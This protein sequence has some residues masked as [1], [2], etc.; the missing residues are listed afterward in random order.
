M[1]SASRHKKKKKNKFGAT[2]PP[3]IDYLKEILR[4]YPDGGQILKE[5]IQNA[6]DAGASAVV[7]IHDERHYGTQSLWSEELRKYQG[8]ALYAFN[9]AAFTEEDWEGIQN[10]GRSIKQDDPTKVGRFGIGFNSVYHITDL[11][12]V[13]SSKNLAIF[14]PQKMMF[15]DEEE[16][17]RWSLD[18]EEDRESILNMRDQFQPF[19]NIV[20]QVNNC[21][22]EKVIREEQYF[23]G[24]LFRFPLRNEA[25]E[26]SDNLYDSKKVTELFDSFIF[27]ADIGLL[28]LRNVS[29]ITLLHIDTNGS[30]SQRLKVSVSHH[31]LE[32][33]GKHES[34]DRKTCF[35]TVSH[36]SQQMEEKSQW[37]VTP[38]L[39]KQ[40]YIL[41]IDSLANKM[42]FNPQVDV[43]FKLE[44][45]RSLCNGRLSCF[46]PLPNN[47]SN[48]TGLPVHINASFGL[49][50][51]RR[52]IK[53]QEEDQKNDEAAMWNELLM[54]DLLPLIYLMMILDAIQLSRCSALPAASV[55]NIWPDLTK[56]VHVD[57]WHK[58][59]KDIL[60]CLF[61]YEIF[62]LADNEK[63]WVSLSDAVF[64]DN[65]ICSDTMS[66]VSKLLIKKGENLV[67]VPEHVLK[68]VKGTFAR[69]DTLKIVTPSFVRDVLHR[70]DME[71]L[72]KDDKYSLLEFVLSDERYTELQGLKL[73]P[74]SDGTFT[75]FSDKEQNTV[76]IDN[77]KFPRSLM[78]FCKERFL[79][80][81]L[82]NSCTMHLRKLATNTKYNIINLDAKH[83][84][85]LTKKHLPIDWRETQAHVTWKPAEDH[86]PPKSWIAE[87][88][89]FLSTECED[90]SVFIGLPLIPLEPLQNS[91]NLILLARLQRNST[92]IFQSSRGSILSDHVQKVVNMAGCTVIKRDEC[93]RHHDIESY[94]LPASPRNVLQVLMNSARDQVIKHI[95]SASL[96]EK[97]EFKVYLSSLDSLSNAEQNL[98]S[99]LPIFS[100]MSGKYVAVKS[101]QAVVL[102][103]NPSIPNNLPMPETIVQC[104]NEADR[105]LLSL[106]NIELLDAAKVAIC[107]V[108]CINTASFQKDEEQTIMSWILDHGSV[109]LSQNE[110]LLTKAKDLNFIE[111]NQGERKQASNFFD[112]GNKTF[113][114]L[115]EA[116]LFPP[117]FYT[118][119]QE[120]LQSLQ[121]LGLK[122][123]E[124]EISTANILQVMKHVQ[125]ISI[126][127][128]NKAF[129]KVDTLVRV[130]NG[131][132]LLSKLSKTER[133]EIMQLQ[134]VPCENPKCLN[135]DQRR[136][137]YKPDEVRDSKYSAI[138]GYVMPLTSKLTARVCKNLG[139]NDP[140]PAEKVLENLSV[141]GSVAA[142]MINPDS[143][144]QFKTMLH[145]IYKYMQENVGNFREALNAK[146]IPWLW[147][148]R[149]F[150]SPKDIV[151]AYP[152]ELDLN[153]YIKKV[154][155]EFLKYENLLRECGVKETLS[156][157]ELEDVLHDIKQRIDDRDPPYGDST[158]LKLSIAVIN[159]MRKNEKFLKDNTPVPVM[160]QNKNF[161]LQY[162]S[163][164]VFCDIS[165]E[166]LDDLKQDN[167]ELY[168]IHEEVLPLT[169][170][171]LKVPF[172]STR[173]LKPQ[174]ITA[175]QEYF[176]IEQCGQSE[177]ITLRIK[178]ILKE[179]NEESDIFKE[180]IQNAE[181][182]GASTCKF[183][184]DFRKHRDPP[185]TLIDDG[186]A[187]CNGPCL[188]IFNNELFSEED[189]KN[190]VKVGSASKANKVEKIGKFGLGFNAVYHVSDIPSILSGKSLL[191][192]DPNVTH[193]EKHIL[194]KGNPGIKLDPFQERLYKS[195]P[196]QFKSYEGIFDCDL[197][198]QNSKK[199]YNGTLIKLPFRTV[200][201]ANKSEISSKV[202]DEERINSFKYNLIE[203]SQNHLLF[204]KNIKS[205]SLQIV[206]EIAFTPLRDDQIETPLKT[207]KEVMN[208]IAVSND[209]LL[210]E[211]K[212]NF[213]KGGI[214]C[215]N[216][217]DYNR[218]QIV[219]IVKNH[220]EGSLTQYWLLYSCI[221]TKDS[222]QMFQ[223][224][225]EHEHVFS[226][227][228]G[229]I[230]VPLHRGA[231]TNVW[232]PDESLL[233]GQAFCFLPLTIET[234]LPVHVNG[235]FAVTSNRKGLWEKGLKSEWNKALLKD[236]INSAYIT[237]L[238]ELKK[239]AQ[240]GNLQNYPF[241]AFWPN[242]EK[243]SKAFLPMVESF[244]SAVAQN[245]NGNSLELFSNGRNWCSMDKATF[246][247]PKIEE[248]RAIGNIAM[249]VF[250]NMGESYSCV[251]S[252][253]SWVRDSFSQC[254]FKEMIKQ[255][256]INWPEFY[257]LVLKNLS[258]LDTHS[259]NALVLN[260][261]DLNDPSVDD[262]L[263]RYPCIPTQNCK[264]LQ[265]IN[266]VVNPSSKV[267]CLYELEE[268]RFVEGTATD[269]FSPKRIQRLSD[270]GMLTDRLPF[271]DIIERAGKVSRVCQQD[272]P[273]CRKHLQ[274]LI[275]SM[276]DSSEDV[277]SQCWAS[278]S[279]I[280][281]LPAVAPFVQQNKNVILLK[282]PA[283]VYS[284][285]CRNIV[286]MTEFTV[287]H[288]NLQ[289]HNMDSVL[290]KLQIRT[291][292]PV[293]TVLQQL[294]KAHQ[295]SDAIE[296]AALLNIAQFCYEYL[297]TYLLEHKYTN[298]IVAFAKSHPFIF[299]EDHFVNVRSVARNEGFEE[300]PYL[301][302][303]PA[304]FSKFERL[305]DCIGITKQFTKEQFVAT[306]EDIKALYGSQPLSMSDLHMCF[307]ILIKGLY[308]VKNK[309]LEN[310]LIPNE[311]GVLTSSCE[312]KFND[313]PW[314]PVSAGVKLTHE[315][316][317]RAVACHFGVKTTRHHTLKNHLVSGF[318][319]L[320]REFGQTEKLT[321][322]IK[323][324]INA[325]PSKK[326]I[327]KEL[328][329]NAD[330]A[331]ATEIH[332]VWD[333]RKHQTK[334]I[335]G[336]KWELVQGP[337]L[338]VYNN[339]TF[340][341]ADLQGIQ[342]LGEGGKHGTLGKTGKYGLGFN[343]VYHLTDCPSILTGDNWLCI[344][345]PN[346]KYVEDA[347]KQSPGCM[348]L[349]TD[350]F[351]K[352]F[353][354]V[355]NT[356]LPGMFALNSGTMFRLPL[357]TEIMAE[358]SEISRH[359][360]TDCNMLQLYNA[361]TEDP[362]GLIIFLKHITKIQFSEIS[363]DGKKLKCYF[364]VE[365]KYTEKSMATKENFNT[366]VQKSLMSGI[367]EPFKTIYSMQ[368][369]YGNK[370][371]QWIIAECFG[372]FK[373][374]HVRENKQMHFK[375]PQAALAACVSS[376]Y[377]HEFIGRA[378][379][380]LPL[381][382]NTG[383][384][385]HVNANFEVDSS[386]RD[387]WKEDGDSLK[388]DWNKTLKVNIISPLY[389]DLLYALRT[390][391]KKDTPTA[392]T[393]LKM[394][395]E[396]F[397]LKYFPCISKEVEKVWYEMILEVYRSFSEDYVP[398][399]PTVH[400]VSET[401]SHHT[402]NTSTLN[403]TV[404]WHSVS[405]P[406]SVNCPYFTTEH[407]DGIFEILDDIGLKLVPHS[408]KI[409]K[410]KENF[411][412]AGVNVSEVS[413]T[414]VVN[415][416]KQISLNDPTQTVNGLPLPISQTL[417]KDKTR[418]SKLLSFCLTNTDAK[419]AIPVPD[420]DGLPLLLTQDQMLR[421]FN[422]RSPK[423]ISRFSS[424]FHEYQ[425]MFADIEV[426]RQH[427]KILR[428]KSFIKDLTIAMGAKY[429]KA[430]LTQML[431]QSLPDQK[432]Q[433]Y[434][435]QKETI[436]WLKTLWSFFDDQDKI[437][438]NG[439]V[440]SEIKKHFNDSPILPVIC[441]SQNNTHFLQTMKN[442][443]EVILNSEN[444][445]AA[446]LIK[447]G[448]MKLDCSFFIGLIN[449]SLKY[450]YPELLQTGDGGAV[451]GPVYRVPH[452]YFVELSNGE[453][454]K[455][456][457]FLQRRI[458]DSK[459]K[460]VYAKMLKSLPLFESISGKRERIDLHRSVFILNSRHYFVF[461][462]LFTIEGCDSIF[463]KYSW[464]NL[465]LAE[466]LNI[467]VLDDLEFCVQFILPFV[468]KMKETKLI[469]F[470]QLLVE[471]GL[472]DPRIVSTLRG[473][474]FIRDI[475]GSRQVASYFYDEKPIYRIMLTEERFVPEQFWN[476]FKGKRSEALCLLKT[477]GLKHEVS[478]EEIIQFAFQI[479]SETKGTTPLEVL[480]KRSKML[481]KTVLMRSE[482]NC[483]L[484]NRIANIKFIFPVKIQQ[485]LCDYHKPFAQEREVVAISGS[486]IERD[487]DHQCL[488]WTSMP[489]LPSEHW[490]PLYFHLKMKN[491]GAVVTPPPEQIA[492]NVRNICSSQCHTDS[493]LKTRQEVFRKSYA[494]LQSVKFDASLF[495]D[496]HIVLVEKGTTLVKT[497]QTAL[498]LRHALEFRPYLY[499]I[500]SNLMKFEDFFR[501][502]GVNERPTN[503][504][505]CTVLREIY[506]DSS[507]KDK[508]QANQQKT[509]QRVVQQ[510]FCLM[511]EEQKGTFFQN[512][513]LYLPSTDGRLYKSSTLFFND[514]VFQASRL[515]GPLETKLKL[516][517]KLNYCH[518]GDDHYEHQRYV[519][520]LLPQ[521]RPKFLSE[522]I[523][524]NLDGTS[525]Q[526]CDYKE[527]CEF[528]NWIKDH[529]CSI[530]FLHGLACLI[531]EDSNGRI[532]QTD[533][534]QMCGT[535]F[536]KIQ[537]ICCET[538]QTELLL[539]L[540]P[541][542]GSKTETDVYVKKQEDGCT[543]YLKHHGD[544]AHKVVNEVTMCLTKEIN[545]LMKNCLAT[546]RLAVLGQLLLCDNMEDVEK[547]LEK[548]G[549]HNSG[550]KEEGHSVL[551]KPGC[552]IPE[553]WHD[554]LDMSF[555]NNFESGE[556]VGFSKDESGEYLYAIVIERLDDSLG[557]TRQ[558]PARYKIQ[559]GSD[560][561]IEVSS[562]DLYQFKREKKERMPTWFTCT[563][564]QPLLTSVPPPH[565][566][567]SV[568]APNRVTPEP[569]PRRAFPQTLKEAKKEIDQSLNE[570]WNMS[571]EDKR[572]ALKRLYLQWHPDKNPGNEELAA[573]AFKYL[574]TRIEELQQ[575]R[576]AHNTSSNV[577]DFRDNFYQWNTEAQSHR[578]GRERFHQKNYRREY[579]FWSHHRETPRPDRE[580]AKRWYEQAQCDINAAHNDT[581]GNTSEWCLFKV[582]QAVEKA[583]IAVVY[584]KIGKHLNNSS[585]TSLAQ[586]VSYYSSQLSSVPITVRQLIELGVDAKK[587]QYPNYHQSPHI[588]NTQYK[589]NNARRALDIATELLL[590]IDQ[591]I[592]G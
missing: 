455:L 49:T 424:L 241:Y 365:K 535:L 94:V 434:K 18:D 401:S 361:L 300:K 208:S 65:T 111:T 560:V 556:Y 347:T 581:G 251:L 417:I 132:N 396:D 137:L 327:L 223:R 368:I 71:N 96:H 127:S 445:I 32:L 403:Y 400:A 432:C 517:E 516:L 331:E 115:F 311:S 271:K 406:D 66:A 59:A 28:F 204:L 288:S 99:L 272:K 383:L 85:V 194:S 362:E 308:K 44:E 22:W 380:S 180:L 151:L 227:P 189:W 468:H 256:T 105:R 376:T 175:D 569:P 13:F 184:L 158:E 582:H 585:I 583:L 106:L 510:L 150:V 439:N 555:L 213:M 592:N 360:V 54:K 264:K 389:A 159:W 382:G 576:T 579:N 302:V 477:L 108:D 426:N 478:D 320:A 500:P 441:P 285:T 265:F 504:Q 148:Q 491:A 537:I 519:Q 276:K 513:P 421:V 564:V 414:V 590:K 462:N 520:L 457:C 107:L 411:K 117:P 461:H 325:Y 243:V 449:F 473:L 346:L 237:T 409:H 363:E 161:S 78:P 196:G 178:N 552:R 92:L 231:Q 253:P 25:S 60:K 46:L 370:Q 284:D 152:F 287:D 57:R 226:L 372:S 373:Q 315:L 428:E 125:N 545:A 179:Y 50:D 352:S 138:V 305:W 74:L 466:V 153:S 430:E 539:N 6:D 481:F 174:F 436:T 386:R 357:R 379:C 501:K 21:S 29:S 225:N 278:L 573:E 525:V 548:H 289:I 131:N 291:N 355:Y 3:F 221:G 77:E 37:L 587:T 527:G 252:L 317:P 547:A 554:C 98:L 169:A 341:E 364:L 310:C 567:T 440:F 246:L 528:G 24:T 503:Q 472:V 343:S 83:V 484:L 523:S 147:N 514:T 123:E 88:W 267:A 165:A 476:I 51:N 384:P 173:I 423:L 356:F 12:C 168:V 136:G 290:Q 335:F 230:A 177:P 334:K 485:A 557:Q 486:L 509:V 97:E 452:S 351:K 318:S 118:K 546:S 273:K 412:A 420:L 294:L 348:Y 181:D 80:I 93:L 338:C 124:K 233:Q 160:A 522:V 499:S 493:L 260:A 469:D 36:I 53:W 100:L 52:Y 191:I 374:N 193:L 344:S 68:D 577:G 269:F 149:E 30:C 280:P 561:F 494:H 521:A 244:Y 496:L 471:L 507:D 31:D 84:V 235:A 337:A 450:V 526:Y 207:S 113:Q 333:R 250:L 122:T 130:L 258:T 529:L 429:L 134:W 157:E 234:G 270:L 508:L 197:S 219:K 498:V 559:V 142:D 413:P 192:L 369:S 530:A 393:F 47:E 307:S 459:I 201:E 119:T 144:F 87:F 176:G 464:V 345:D 437:S 371:S 591:Y 391:I 89:K 254:G 323:N 187:L 186:M 479:E 407:H 205:I 114:D 75:S 8:P 277:N 381:P 483:N 172:L 433:L 42:R 435:A 589:V 422:S 281:F 34:L 67:T 398:V 14:D 297:N 298:C 390:V 167:E 339:R 558:Y 359:T 185:E 73:L 110:L 542:E 214:I 90:L 120:M 456:Q 568:P 215:N 399:I 195:F 299:I 72:S 171:W 575:G 404:N 451:L 199:T 206:P 321:V 475:Y 239:M 102:T 135:G 232:S 572:K 470:I 385:V 515:E 86:H 480:Q 427:L 340:S 301:Y 211:S 506:S 27:D 550:H 255:K 505:Y 156:D 1:S 55:Y 375:V 145:N 20:N 408:L 236:A 460:S 216:I 565:R 524:E 162:L 163:K 303:L 128:P 45:D 402:N 531:R 553:E 200:E 465:E 313:S 388:T 497:H 405:E 502:I 447:L 511:K 562:L 563:D 495:S 443:S 182:A 263:K 490:S 538:L 319:L 574:Q 79:P 23:K 326:D 332:F 274:C 4:R 155:E 275:E 81:D 259:R 463:L 416:L 229:G 454:E 7:F 415:S 474:A 202:Y 328:I 279:Q 293:V 170:R 116:D 431:G 518:L 458:S 11:P 70:S 378:F 228:I 295:H 133:G 544:M 109:L 248:N 566:C 418:C 397:Y 2:P 584:R 292:P 146:C 395:L 35:K 69:S 91:D 492:K 266:Q 316:I 392:L 350:E 283:E 268:G 104:A 121:R 15:G 296:K 342:Q 143:N 448:F 154:P 549:I 571:S 366:H 453:L 64:P 358:K 322:R 533:A 541:L 164:T 61:Q 336:E 139:L 410:I 210:Q 217:T 578:R 63:I 534:V 183:L 245:A 282:K 257:E 540:E 312:L 188:W 224:R 240:N 512:N 17:Y 309:K 209:K 367:P 166:G 425:E 58:V 536:S 48:K 212:E 76:L 56:T 112:P 249:K 126:H 543:F 442:I 586:Q 580:E 354:D 306:L 438:Q 588:P 329:Q 419:K 95:A 304:I 551:P 324:I 349:L 570:I 394:E 203:N 482:K 19:Q 38:C 101:K 262:L 532:S 43:A 10:V 26:I 330:D 222:L 41:E 261:I 190:I 33:K 247:N 198:V 377:K 140:P 444:E 39:L 16:G 103:T 467:H 5:L 141:L 218:A 40:G 446:I 489:I 9:D 242:T 238:L 62:H 82:S 314:M 488:I 353:E 286:S 129:K 487:T 387:L 220:P